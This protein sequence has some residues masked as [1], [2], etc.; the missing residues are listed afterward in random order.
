MGGGW[1]RGPPS[2]QIARPSLHWG[3]SS[4]SWFPAGAIRAGAVRAG[5]VPAG[6][7]Q[8]G[9]VRAG[10]VHGGA[11]RGGAVQGGAV[12]PCFWAPD[13]ATQ[14]PT[15]LTSPLVER[16]W[17]TVLPRG[18]AGTEP[19]SEGQGSPHCP[20][21]RGRAV[22]A[23]TGHVAAGAESARS[24]TE[25]TA[26]G[27]RPVHRPVTGHGQRSHVQT[28]PGEVTAGPARPAATQRSPRRLRGRHPPPGAPAASSQ[29]GGHI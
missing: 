24:D 14:L 16:G 28:V 4:G 1:H 19:R 8:G 26:A 5:A 11:G 18:T 2:D 27:S 7:V 10:A 9:A 17:I 12:N 25:G 22:W 23:G 15:L 20:S 29:P 3:L 6:D 13:W 21:C